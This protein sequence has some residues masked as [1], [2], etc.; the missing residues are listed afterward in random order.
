MNTILLVLGLTVACGGVVAGQG[1][2][3]DSQTQKINQD[4]NKTTSRPNDASRSIDF[5]KGKTKAREHIANPY[6]FSAPRDRLINAVLAVL[7]DQ[8]IVVD[9]TACRMS[10]GF[11]CTQPYVFSRGAVITT[12][13]L[14]RYSVV[15]GTES[16]WSGGR[17]TLSIEIQ[18]IDGVQ[19]SVSVTARVEGK[20]KNGMLTEW[21]SLPSSGEAEEEFLTKLVALVTGK[22]VDGVDD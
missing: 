18:P 10:E 15:P 5:G 6:R 21:T 1:K 4:S 12:N 20:A 19:S 8:K 9:E 3:I 16:S 7:K 13:E 2:G 11:I 22:S 17:Y 14:N